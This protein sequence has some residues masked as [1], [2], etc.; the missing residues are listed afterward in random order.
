MTSPLD[1]AALRALR[2][3][4]YSMRRLSAISGSPPEDIAVWLS[5]ALLEHLF[6]TTI[7][8]SLLLEHGYLDQAVPL[9]RVALST[10]TNVL[11]IWDESDDANGVALQY[12]A[13]S[14]RARHSRLRTRGGRDRLDQPLAEHLESEEL[15]RE[16]QLLD[17]FEAE[18]GIKPVAFGGR[19]DTWSG[20]SDRDL[21]SKM[22]YDDDW[23][24]SYVDM[25]NASHA[26]VSGIWHR[27]IDTSRFDHEPTFTFREVANL[28]VTLFERAATAVAKHLP[29]DREEAIGRAATAF[30]WA[31]DHGQDDLDLY[32]DARPSKYDVDDEENTVFE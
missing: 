9:L 13:F 6:D 3:A 14:Q 7:A 24:K 11:A 1:A 25:S 32:A 23:L 16:R 27:L 30:W 28:T 22:W 8:V 20:L 5:A 19:T 18:R 21:L 2:D 17:R 15:E 12:L 4:L 29:G 26:N 31:A 10:T